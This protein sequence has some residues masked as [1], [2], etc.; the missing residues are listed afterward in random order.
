MT[1]FKDS[2]S[3][4]SCQSRPPT[5]NHCILIL[6]GDSDVVTEEVEVFRAVV[7]LQEGWRD[8]VRKLRRALD[9]I[10]FCDE[11]VPWGFI[12]WLADDDGEDVVAACYEAIMGGAYPCTLVSKL[13]LS[14]R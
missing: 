8:L 13:V 14:R 7:D 12:I 11:K 2:P 4:P 1:K 3:H 5:K 10:E 9:S 6:D